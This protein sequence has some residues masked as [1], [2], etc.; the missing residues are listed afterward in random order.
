MCGPSGPLQHTVRDTK[1]CLR[2]EHCKN[3]SQHYELSD[4]DVSTVRDQARTVRPPARTVR[5]PA[6][7]VRSVKNQKN[8]KVTG[9]VKCIFSILADR[10][11]C[12]TG[13]F[14][15]AL[16]DL[17]RRIKC[18][19]A[20]DIAVTADRCDFSHWCAGVDYLDQGRRPS[21]VG[22]KEATTRKW[23]EAINTSPTTSIHFIQ[24]LHSFTFNTRA[25]NPL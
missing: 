23:L 9:S 7:T 24:A 14:A 19:I 5:P 22:K 17:L 15:T 18:S 2:Q 8:L 12:T 10:P 21:T 13:L 3:A 1:V 16:S 20:I 11:G 4:G 6:Q 25:S